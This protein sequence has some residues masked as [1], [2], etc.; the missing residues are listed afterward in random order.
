MGD[1]PS[2][3]SVVLHVMTPH[4][5]CVR[6]VQLDSIFSELIAWMNALFVISHPKDHA[7]LVTLHA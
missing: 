6:Y 5:H 7:S 1:A 2:A 3:R 4:P